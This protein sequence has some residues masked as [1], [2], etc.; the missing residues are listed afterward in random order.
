MPREQNEGQNQNMKIG[1]TFFGS[2]AKF[3]SLGTILKNQNCSRK[4]IRSTLNSGTACYLSVQ[5][6][7]TSSLPSKSMQVKL[8][9]TMLSPVFHMGVKLGQSQ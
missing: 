6:L 1:N 3:G 4:E 2:V 9:R 7:L 5:N 8:Y